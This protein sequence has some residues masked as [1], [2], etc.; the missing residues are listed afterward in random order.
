MHHG[1]TEDAEKKT[2][3]QGDRE[4][5]RVACSKS[6]SLRIA[7]SAYVHSG[8]PFSPLL[9]ACLLLRAIGVSV[10][11][12]FCFPGVTMTRRERNTALAATA[13]AVGA[14]LAVRAAV[15]YSRW[16][17]LRGKVVLITGGSRGLGLELAREF[18]R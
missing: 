4:T 10:V 5:R 18:A 2:G 9:S 15:R 3:R 12:P 7:S 8:L 14:I 13:G 16:M 1:D 6:L 11:N 17:D